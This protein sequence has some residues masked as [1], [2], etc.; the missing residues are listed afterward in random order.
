MATLY[1]H[2]K[3]ASTALVELVSF[4]RFIKSKLSFTSKGVT[5]LTRHLPHTLY[6]VFCNIYCMK[7]SLKPI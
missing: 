2:R 7:H 6:S 5:I 1:H 4:N 3:Y